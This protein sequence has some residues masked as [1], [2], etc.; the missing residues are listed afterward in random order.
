MTSTVDQIID[1]YC[2]ALNTDPNKA[3]Y[4]DEATSLTKECYFGDMYNMG[5]ALRACHNYLLVNTRKH[6]IPGQITNVT[7]G[8][9]SLGLWSNK[10]KGSYS[11]LHMTVPGTKLLSLIH[12]IGPAASISKVGAT[13]C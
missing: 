2:P 9:V 5:I 7:E 1:V 13:G 3:V 11:D 12:S 4:I 6:G 8:R 10:P